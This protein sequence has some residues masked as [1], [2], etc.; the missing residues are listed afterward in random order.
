MVQ[1]IPG[2]EQAVAWRRA[3]WGLFKAQGLNHVSCF[4][5]AQ[6]L[7]SYLVFQMYVLLHAQCL[8][9]LMG[10]LKP[11]FNLWKAGK[12]FAGLY[13]RNRAHDLGTTWLGVLGYITTGRELG[14]SVC[15]CAFECACVW[16][17]VL[18]LQYDKSYC[19]KEVISQAFTP[20]WKL[21]DEII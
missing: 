6:L 5:S 2:P 21:L 8:K 3:P 18:L 14:R 19:G 4:F 17:C 1:W 20:Q 10:K 13:E 11:T 15:V 7:N 12:V 9:V 16:V